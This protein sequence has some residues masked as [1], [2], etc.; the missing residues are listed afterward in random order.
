MQIAGR[1]ASYAGGA[2]GVRRAPAGILTFHRIAA[3]TA[4]LPVPLHN[5]PPQR[6]QDQLEGLQRRGFR[7]VPLDDLLARQRDGRPLPAQH[8]ALTFDDGFGSVYT[9]AWPVLRRLQAPA[10]IF[11]NTA[12]LDQQDPFPF[13]SWGVS[14]RASAPID[15]YRPLSTAECVEMASSGLIALGVH[16]HTHEDFRGRPTDFAADLRTSVQIIR[17]RFE[18]EETAFAFPF[19][20]VSKGFCSRALMDEARNVGVTCALTTE[21]KNIAA[22]CDPF[23]WGRFNSFSWDTAP[24]LAGKLSGWYSWAPKLWQSLTSRA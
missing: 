20:S 17:E 16:T 19:G 7:F 15:S 23:G 12:Y 10:T 24:T 2:C 6:F 18:V 9:E 4:G 3:P 22:E 21:C 5:V 14:Q 13:D 8:V 1:F 11:L